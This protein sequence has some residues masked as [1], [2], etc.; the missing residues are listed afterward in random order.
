[1]KCIKVA[2]EPGHTTACCIGMPIVVKDL[3]FCFVFNIVNM[4]AAVCTHCIGGQLRVPRSRW[5]D[6][7]RSFRRALRRASF[8]CLCTHNKTKQKGGSRAI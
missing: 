8:C 5:A 2:C 1:M 7:L 6:F 4:C 3:P